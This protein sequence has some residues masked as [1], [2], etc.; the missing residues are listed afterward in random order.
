LSFFSFF[1]SGGQ[2]GF[3]EK[4]PPGPPKKLLS[5]WGRTKQKLLGI[6]KFIQESVDFYPENNRFADEKSQ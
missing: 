1:A 2:G 3:F 6:L 4:S 5:M